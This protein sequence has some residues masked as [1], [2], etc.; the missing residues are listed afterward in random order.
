MALI[1]NQSYKKKI[2]FYNNANE[3]KKVVISI[4]VSCNHDIPKDLLS[5]IETHINSLFF[6]NYITEETFLK[7]LRMQKEQEKMMKENNKLK[8]KNESLKLKA[9]EK[10]NKIK[11]EKLEDKS[12]VKSEIDKLEKKSRTS[13]K[14]PEPEVEKIIPRF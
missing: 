2:A 3:E 6:N 4:G 7:Q 1:D 13:K 5:N 12:H 11:L 8:E 14:E 9:L 10:A